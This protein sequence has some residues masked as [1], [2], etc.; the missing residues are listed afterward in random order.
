MGVLDPLWGL[1]E[2]TYEK[3]LYCVW[4]VVSDIK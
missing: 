1:N 3:Y 4:H 2:I